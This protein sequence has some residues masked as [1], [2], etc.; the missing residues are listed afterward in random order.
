MQQVSAAPQI[1]SGQLLPAG[2]QQQHPLHSIQAAT[3]VL[4]LQ[5]VLH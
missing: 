4:G 2:S 3:A 1:A 5:T